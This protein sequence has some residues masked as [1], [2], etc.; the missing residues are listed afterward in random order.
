MRYL[1]FLALAVVAVLSTG[2][3]RATYTLNL[4]P[5]GSGTIHQTMAMTSVAKQQAGMVMGASQG[6]SLMPTPEK[7]RAAAAQMGKGV[8]FVSSTPYNTGGFDGVTA[9]YAF[10][11]IRTL[12]LSMDKMMA[13]GMDSPIA[14]KAPDAEVKLAFA[15]QGNVTN[16][17]LMLP[18]LP[19][20]DDASRAAAEQ[21][22]KKS[23]MPA[24]MPP[25]AMAMMKQMLNGLLFE[26]ALNIDGTIIS[27]NAPYVAGNRILLLQLDGTELL[28]SNMNLGQL[29]GMSTTGMANIEETLRTTPG[30]KFVTLPELK[31]SFR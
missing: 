12:S 10:D 29:M 21:A 6:G 13:A 5:D 17:T 16:L 15:R 24:S 22:A 27:T 28:K 18:P 3:I 11:D 4:K 2:C 9:V 26:V 14:D 30:V 1:R 7:L 31:I 25:E 20:P 8:R 23:G 19:K